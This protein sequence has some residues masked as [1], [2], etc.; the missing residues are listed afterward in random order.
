MGMVYKIL[1]VDDDQIN[2]KLMQKRL[3]E[4]GY[5]VILAVDGEVGLSRAMTEKPDLIILDVEMPK[6]DGY[7]FLMQRNKN[8][9]LIGAPVIVLTAHEEMQPIFELKGVKDYLVKP[10]NFDVL[11]EKLKV[12]LPPKE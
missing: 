2:I 10:I 4:K 8:K 11:F 7:Q 6:M 3:E 12:Y 5:Q 1:C 9:E